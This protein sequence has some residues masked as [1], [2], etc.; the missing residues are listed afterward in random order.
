MSIF[1]HPPS[2]D[3]DDDSSELSPDEAPL[4]LMSPI[5]RDSSFASRPQTADGPFAS[6][7]HSEKVASPTDSPRPLPRPITTDVSSSPNSEPSTPRLDSRERRPQLSVQTNLDALRKLNSGFS[8]SPSS[9][10]LDGT[11][12]PKHTKNSDRVEPAPTSTA[13]A[14]PRRYVKQLSFLFSDP[15]VD[16]SEDPSLL[17]SARSRPIKDAAQTRW[18]MGLAKV[19]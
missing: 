13:L 18:K 16:S 8:S 9:P 12:S 2:I 15:S 10:N 7:F 17:G 19:R 1:E 14:S 5:S 3:V 11:S 6:F 4:S